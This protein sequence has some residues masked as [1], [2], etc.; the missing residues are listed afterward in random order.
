MELRHFVQSPDFLNSYS[1]DTLGRMTAETQQGQPGSNAVA[2]KG[3]SFGYD[4]I[5]DITSIERYTNI[6]QPPS[7]ATDAADTTLAYSTLGQLTSEQHAHN[8]STLENLSWTFDTLDRVSTFTSYDGLAAYGYDKASQVVSA[9]YSGANP[10]PN[11][12]ETYDPS[13][14]RNATGD[15]VGP[16]NHLTSDGTFDWAYDNEGNVISRVRISN[17]PANDYQLLFDWDCTF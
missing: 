4:P 9:T 7:P 17:A 15:T 13:G 16:N 5:G 6:T 3:I 14:V 12:T 11:Q 2:T 8:G 1:F 10:P